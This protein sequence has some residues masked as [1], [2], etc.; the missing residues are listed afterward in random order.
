MAVLIWDSLGDVTLNFIQSWHDDVTLIIQ[1]E[2]EDL[3]WS[4]CRRKKNSTVHSDVG[5]RTRDDRV[6]VR[7][8]DFLFLIVIVWYLFFFVSFQRSLRRLNS[9]VQRLCSAVIR[10]SLS[11]ILVCCPLSLSL[12]YS[13]AERDF[14]FFVAE[15]KLKSRLLVFVVWG[16][17]S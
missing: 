17:A 2:Y 13:S 9:I 11:M 14:F 6:F 3:S 8:V 12:T 1:G 7:S 15:E 4:V 16:A 5:T 10:F